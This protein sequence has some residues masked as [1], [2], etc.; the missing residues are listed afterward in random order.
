MKTLPIH[1]DSGRRSGNP[2]MRTFGIPSNVNRPVRQK[3]S[4]GFICPNCASPQSRVTDS[5]ANAGGEIR[6][7]RICM[8]CQFRFTTY[9]LYR[10]DFIP[11]YEI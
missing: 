2:A 9:E 4:I 8:A 7:R 1:L 10:P 6:R 11:S 3:Q 5:R